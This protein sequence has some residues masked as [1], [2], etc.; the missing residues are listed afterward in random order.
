M[1]G[2]SGVTPEERHRMIAETAYFLAQERGF[3]GG[4]TVVD[5]MEAERQVDRKLLV[6]ATAQ[7]LERLQSGVATATK[8]LAALTR[9]A[10]TLPADARTEL[11]A[12][13]DKLGELK[14]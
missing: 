11:Y 5:W 4:D 10:S 8:K 14:D 7:L 9:R 2:K 3:A 12:D 13:V 6:L 1:T